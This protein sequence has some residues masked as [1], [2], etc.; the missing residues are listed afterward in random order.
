MRVV[1][2]EIEFSFVAYKNNPDEKKRA[3]LL[4]L[5]VAWDFLDGAKQLLEINVT[6]KGKDG[7]T[8]VCPYRIVLILHTFALAFCRTRSCSGV[9]FEKP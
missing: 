8:K 2:E 3:R 9:S 6:Q 5:S 1:D 7:R 4:D